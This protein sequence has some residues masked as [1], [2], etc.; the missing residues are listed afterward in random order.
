V[1]AVATFWAI[2]SGLS[3]VVRIRKH[4]RSPSILSDR[5]PLISYYRTRRFLE[6]YATITGGLINRWGVINTSFYFIVFSG[7]NLFK[8]ITEIKGPWEKLFSF[9]LNTS[10]YLVI[11]RVRNYLHFNQY[12]R[13]NIFL[14]L[15]KINLSKLKPLSSYCEI[16]VSQYYRRNPQSSLTSPMW[17]FKREPVTSRFS[18]GD[19]ISCP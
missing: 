15:M 13:E 3:P 18:T 8:Q 2:A 6:L 5:G 9:N 14:A 10:F 19:A 1:L 7:E 4:A 17:L 16:R 12:C 11:F